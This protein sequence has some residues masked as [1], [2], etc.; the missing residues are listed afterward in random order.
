[1][2]KAVRFLAD[3]ND[4]Y[5]LLCKRVPLKPL[6]TD[7]ENEKAAE[8]CDELLGKGHRLSRSEKDYLEVLTDLIVK[9]ESKW[10]EESDV[11]PRQLVRFLM[12]QNGLTQTD[13]IPIFGTSSRVSEFLSG[14]RDLSLSQIQK[15]AK[16]FNLSTDAFMPRVKGSINY[17]LKLSSA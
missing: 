14:R 10:Q 13:L 8:I 2:A 6:R 1:M 16:R 5:A 4:A 17:S 7:K 11:E 15:L 3:T 9:Y 12:E